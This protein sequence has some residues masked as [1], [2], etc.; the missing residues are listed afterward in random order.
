MLWELVRKQ[1]G[2]VARRQLLAHGV[3]VGAIRHRVASG[4][5]HRLARGVYAVGRPEVGTYGEWM[6][7]VLSC[8]DEALLSHDAAASLW[9]LRR[10][11][12]TIDVVVPAALPRRRPGVR[13]HRR[14]DLSAANRRILNGIPATDVVFTLLDLASRD[15]KD[16]LERTVNDAD[17]LD[18]IDP[19]ELRAAIEPLPAAR[20]GRA[21]LAALLDS[22]TFALTDSELERR[23][24]RLVHAAKLSPPETQAW[25]DGFRVDFYW[26]RLGLV[27]E[28]DGLRYHRTA[29]QQRK[30]R[31]RDQ[32][33][34]AAGR[35]T[36][37]FA[38]SQVRHQPDHVIATLTAVTARLSRS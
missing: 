15:S 8:G 25:I 9:G 32:V 38:A 24:L 26:R 16:Q 29:A 23:F 7:A 30:D 31:L 27:V 4:R 18:L 34:T 12:R 13:V 1:H 33:H 36:L 28:T 19:E 6:A 2:V 22:Q 5:L 14:S 11:P 20:P 21:A 37:R 17:R 3:S 35:T 10:A